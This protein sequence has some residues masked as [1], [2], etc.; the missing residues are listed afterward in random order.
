MLT[1]QSLPLDVNNTLCCTWQHIVIVVDLSSHQQS[2]NTLISTHASSALQRQRA[3][4]QCS[5]TIKSKLTLLFSFFFASC[6]LAGCNSRL[7]GAA[8]LILD[9]TDAHTV[10]CKQQWHSIQCL[11]DKL[12][13][14]ITAH[15]GAH[16]MYKNE[17]CVRPTSTTVQPTI[18]YIFDCT[19]CLA[20]VT[21]MQPQVQSWWHV[22]PKPVYVSDKQ[23]AVKLSCKEVITRATAAQCTLQ[24]TQLLPFTCQ[25]QPPLSTPA[26]SAVNS[27]MF[28]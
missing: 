8:Q 17:L 1:I 10:L 16:T 24:R 23:P 13:S 25:T 20:E 27:S 7:Q 22:L 18:K 15:W 26:C 12:A 21:N 9:E 4:A 2:H 19:T 5:A 3:L 11:E 6:K 14:F 28:Q